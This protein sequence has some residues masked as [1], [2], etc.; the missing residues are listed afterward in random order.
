MENIT[1]RIPGGTADKRPGSPGNEYRMVLVEPHVKVVALA[2]GVGGAKLAY[3]LSKILSPGQLTIIGNVG[4]DFELYG[5][6]ISPDLDTVMYTLAEVANPVTGW[7]LAGDTWHMLDMLKRYGEEAW[8]RLGDRDLATHLLRTQGLAQGMTLTAVTDRLARSLGVQHRF[9]PVTDDPLATMVDTVEYGPLG[10]QE[11]FVRR[12]WKPTVRRVWFEGAD[13]ARLTPAAET[14]L[15]EA[16]IMIVCPSNPVLSIAP[17]LAVPGVRE[18]IEQRQGVCVAV[19]PFIGGKAIKGP[20]VKVMNELELDISPRGLVGYYDG[21]LDG[22]VIDEVDR[23]R[24]RAEQRVSVL[25]TR[26]LMQ[27]SEDKARLARDCLV[28]AWSLKK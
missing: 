14:A 12:Q 6:H 27:S 24:V 1:L 10:F 26:T 21:L 20:A 8:F 17:I 9:L 28:W 3:G 7:G 15:R 22:L 5:L 13:Q 4:D 19:S 18:A 16:R 23:G 25:V 11:Y 2:G